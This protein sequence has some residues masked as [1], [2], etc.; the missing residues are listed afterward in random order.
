VP[1]LTPALIEIIWWLSFATIS[2]LLASG[3]SWR[4]VSL[5][6]HAKRARQIADLE[7]YR[8]RLQIVTSEMLSQANELDQK[9][10]YVSGEVSDA[11]SKNLGLACDELVR[12]GETL[13]LIEQ[14]LEHRNVKESREGILRSCR[15][16][17]KIS[18][19]LHDIRLDEPKLLDDK[20]RTKRSPE[21]QQK[22]QHKQ[23]PKDQKD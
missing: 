14:L 4:R 19:E 5:Y 21:F 2:F 22:E 15:M 6:L 17:A 13:P 23:K 9:S 11:W 12:L 18:R 20:N 3:Y 1:P 7:R 8:K 16:A 10:K